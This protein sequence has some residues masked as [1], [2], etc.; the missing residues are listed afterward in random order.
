M[1]GEG[2]GWEG[3]KM[4]G[5]YAGGGGGGGVFIFCNNRKKLEILSALVCSALLCSSGLGI[6]R[7]R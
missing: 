5:F 3:S 7:V 2:R 1:G 6:V 4:G